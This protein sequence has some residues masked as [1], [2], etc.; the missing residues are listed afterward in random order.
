MVYAGG[1]KIEGLGSSSWAS[2]GTSSRA[3]QL[4]HS[5]EG[6]EDREYDIRCWRTR[7]VLGLLRSSGDADSASVALDYDLVK[8]N[9]L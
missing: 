7:P 5:S 8:V 9:Q 6:R 2:W 1:R 4:E 3:I